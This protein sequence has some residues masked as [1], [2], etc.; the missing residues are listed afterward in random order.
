[1]PNADDPLGV[2][3]PSWSKSAADRRRV[4]G[5]DVDRLPTHLNGLLDRANRM[6]VLDP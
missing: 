2:F 5:E 4:E 1:M 3:Q 6:T